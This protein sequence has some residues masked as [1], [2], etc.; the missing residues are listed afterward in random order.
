M[1]KQTVQH[2]VLV[3]GWS[4]PTSMWED[5]FAE[6]FDGY[7]I[8]VLSLAGLTSLDECSRAID[9][10]VQPG[11]LVA[12][13]SLGGQLALNYLSNYSSGKLRKGFV[14]GVALLQSTPCFVNQDGWPYGVTTEDFDSLQGLVEAE[15]WS[16]LVR[17]FSFLLLS[18]SQYRHLDK[19]FLHLV[20]TVESL[21]PKSSLEFGLG[22]LKSLDLRQCLENISTPMY[23]LLGSH[24]SLIAQDLAIYI[25]NQ[26]AE[27]PVANECRVKVVNDMGHLP[28]A[29]HAMDIKKHLFS[30]LET[31]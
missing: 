8:D 19:K 1:S 23:W 28:C 9:D 2:I 16:Q 26:V 11:T 21:P 7:S 18:G 25:E 3:N 6:G 27:S 17:R 30:F 12:A 20:Y 24:D 5:F 13:W 10:C 15:E 29:R 14:E 22:L 31:L 4:A